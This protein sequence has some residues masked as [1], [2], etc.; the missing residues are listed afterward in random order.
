MSVACPLF[1]L[2]SLTSIYYHTS[3]ARR[4]VAAIDVTELALEVGF[5]AG[6]YTRKGDCASLL[7]GREAR[8][9]MDARTGL[10]HMETRVHPARD[11][12]LIAACSSKDRMRRR[13]SPPR[14]IVAT[15]LR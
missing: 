12:M 3:A 5:L 7:T 10:R 6:H 13:A 1:L 15:A 4:A 14:V 11:Q 2:W 9:R 8:R